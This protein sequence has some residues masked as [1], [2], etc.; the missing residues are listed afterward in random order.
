VALHTRQQWSQEAE[1]LWLNRSRK[2]QIKTATLLRHL[3]E[4][5]AEIS[6]LELMGQLS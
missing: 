2:L 3:I 1:G 6:I 5:R 4:G